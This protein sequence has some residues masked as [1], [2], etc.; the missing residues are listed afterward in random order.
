[1]AGSVGKS[2]RLSRGAGRYDSRSG[3]FFAQTA[4]EGF[5]RRREYGE[6]HGCRNLRGF[7]DEGDPAQRS[8]RSAQEVAGTDAVED[9]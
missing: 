8:F 7:R 9:G 4:P 6:Y 3:K 1:M 2:A 5:A